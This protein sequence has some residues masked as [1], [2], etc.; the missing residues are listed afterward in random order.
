MT[1]DDDKAK[2]LAKVLDRLGSPHDGERAA[3]GQAVD[4][5]LREKLGLTWGDVAEAISQVALSRA[6]ETAPREDTGWYEIRDNKGQLG[7]GRWLWGRA[8]TVRARKGPRGRRM[9]VVA[10]NG[11]VLRMSAGVQLFQDLD[12]AQYVAAA[13]VIGE[14]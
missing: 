6:E 1:L 3:A 12:E 2:T 13:A 9:W 8:L 4:R 5:F 14:D 7:Y 11:R 10:V